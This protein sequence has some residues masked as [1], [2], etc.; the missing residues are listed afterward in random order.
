MAS[1]TGAVQRYTPHSP[2]CHCEIPENVR[3]L[4]KIT[5][6]KLITKRS[7]A[8][9][10]ILCMCSE[11]QQALC[12]ECLSHSR[13]LPYLTMTV[14]ENWHSALPLSDYGCTTAR[15]D[16][17]IYNGIVLTVEYTFI[18]MKTK[19][20]PNHIQFSPIKTTPS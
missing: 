9:N 13:P 2:S 7:K 1:E 17:F 15:W 18:Y 12:T 5:V 19:R 16:D 6:S 11:S 3:R 10:H 8:N 20:Y 4:S 14:S